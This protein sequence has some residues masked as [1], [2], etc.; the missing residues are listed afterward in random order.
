MPVEN[1]AGPVVPG[2][3][4]NMGLNVYIEQFRR[5][6]LRALS[7]LGYFKMQMWGGFAMQPHARF[8]LL[9]FLH[10]MCLTMPAR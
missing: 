4:T 7:I 8:S 2:R 3:E 1:R 5:L 6:I 9:F 10:L